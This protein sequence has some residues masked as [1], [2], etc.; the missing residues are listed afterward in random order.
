M[1]LKIIKMGINGEGIGYLNGKPVFVPGCLPGERAEVIEVRDHGSYATAELTE[2]VEKSEDR[3]LA[4]CRKQRAC[5]GCA[6]MPIRYP[7]QL[8]YKQQLL[9]EALGKYAGYHGPIEKTVECEHIFGYRNKANLPVVERNGQLFNAMYRQ[10]TNIPVIIE[11]CPLHDQKL[12]AVRKQVLSVL[13]EC[14]L[15]GYK[16][17]KGIRHLMIRGFRQYQVVLITGNTEIPEKAISQISRIPGVTG[18]FQGI[19]TQKDPVSMM[20]DSLKLL[21]GDRNISLKM[22]DLNLSLQPQA[23][24]QLNREQAEKLYGTVR[25]M[26]DGHEV[27]IEAYCGTGL[28]SLLLAQKC[29]K[30]TGIDINASAIEDAQSNAAANGITNAEFICSDAAKETV[31]LLEEGRADTLV[32][33]PPRSGL[34]DRLLDVINES[35]LEKMIYVSCN[36]ATLGKNIARLKNFRIERVVP[37]DMFPQTANVEA[38]VRLTRKKK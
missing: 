35:S 16:D 6:L 7:R 5:G 19:N 23:F 38:I 30:V 3:I 34:D 8:Y 27:V 24:F 32:V 1:E 28:I 4:R 20:P 15:G 25:E 14:R 11:E 17:K 26:T 33:D 21:W 31:R 22:M 10:G 13:N 36:P 37:L 9:K 18:L 2:V 29:L 12:E